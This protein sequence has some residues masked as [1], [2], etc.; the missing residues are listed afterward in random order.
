MIGERKYL[1]C[2]TSGGKA[3]CLPCKDGKEY[4]DKENYSD[5]C[6]R[7]AFCDG[8]HGM[9]LRKQLKMCGSLEPH[10]TQFEIE[11]HSSTILAYRKEQNEVSWVMWSQILRH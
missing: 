5:K 11:T 10:M 4:M 1:D 2:T 9:Y 8:E 7:C 6:R 3:S